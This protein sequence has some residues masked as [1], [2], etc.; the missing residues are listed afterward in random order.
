MD[1]VVLVFVGKVLE[2]SSLGLG[3]EEGREDTL[4]E[5]NGAEGRMGQSKSFDKSNSDPIFCRLTVNMKRAKISRM[6]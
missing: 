5:E 1:K 4:E 6:C 2:R 3:E